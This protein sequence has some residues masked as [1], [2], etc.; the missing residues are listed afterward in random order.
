MTTGW[1]RADI[2]AALVKKGS[3]L[4]KLAAESGLNPAACQ[5][6]V[7]GRHVGGEIAIATKLG[8]PL[9]ELWP[10]RWAP[11]PA[12]APNLPAIR[13]DGRRKACDG[14]GA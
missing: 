12:E 3:N 4:A 9:W 11:P 2:Q 10:D 13:L 8:V 7:H 6:A 5:R 14:N 1:H